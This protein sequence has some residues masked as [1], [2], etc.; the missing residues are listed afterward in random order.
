[1]N[2]YNNLSNLISS[3]GK[4]MGIPSVNS[5]IVDRESVIKN[6]TDSFNFGN[7]QSQNS[8]SFLKKS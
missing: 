8:F 2:S 6:F 7:D 4:L 1:M 5:P 3:D